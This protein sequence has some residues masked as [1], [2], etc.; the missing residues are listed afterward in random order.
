M[1]I[2]RG[3]VVMVPVVM[4]RMVVGM[5]VVMRVS[6]AMIVPMPVLMIVGMTGDAGVATTANSAHIR[7]PPC[8]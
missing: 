4:V 7:A 1:Q 6:M 2:A 5:P 8:P 3:A